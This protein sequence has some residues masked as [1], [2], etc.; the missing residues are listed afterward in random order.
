MEMNWRSALDPVLDATVFLSFTSIGYRLRKGAWSENLPKMTGKV[1]VITGANSGI[2]FECASAMAGL[3]AKVVMVC[4]NQTRGESA[5]AK[6]QRRFPMAAVDLLL[7]DM[8]D[9]HA[10]RSLSDRIL[11]TYPRVDRLVL[12]AG[13]LLNVRETSPQGFEKTF[14]TNLLGPILLA[15]SL[16][17]ALQR[18]KGARI[19][20]V[21]SGGMYTQRL[22]LQIIQ[23]TKGDYDGVVAYAQTKRAQVILNE[24]WAERLE[25]MDI[26]VYAMHPGWADTPGVQN[27]LPRFHTLLKR[28]LRSPTEGADTLLWLAATQDVDGES[29]DLFF[30]RKV[31]AKVILPWTRS[32][33]REKQALWDLCMRLTSTDANQAAA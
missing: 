9:L 8:S 26:E 29:G 17:P 6:I 25:A 5:K 16:V 1:A 2:G 14:A 21:T 11:A 3:G 18:A 28:W 19:I 32:S 20:Q 23:G 12:N 33:Q 31:R 10:V 27:S 7:C 22:D 30:D 24:L 15:E 4:R 13:V